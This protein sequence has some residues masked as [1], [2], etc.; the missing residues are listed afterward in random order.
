MLSVGHGPLGASII[1][2][3]VLASCSGGSH[4]SD[5]VPTWPGGAPKSL[6]P[7]PGTPEYD[8]FRQELDTEAARD[9]SKDP[10]RPR[11]DAEKK[12]LPQ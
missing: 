7:R 11:G 6:P 1:V 12:G 3:T 2:G 5:Y 8:K 10:P 4:V 9:K